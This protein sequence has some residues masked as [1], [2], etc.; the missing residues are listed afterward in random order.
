MLRRVPHLRAIGAG[1]DERFRSSLGQ[2]ES[3]AQWKSRRRAAGCCRPASCG[4]AG[5]RLQ[6]GASATWRTQPT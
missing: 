6:C 5:H 1:A 4:A 2:P 3:A